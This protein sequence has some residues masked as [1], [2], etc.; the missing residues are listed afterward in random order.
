MPD[1]PRGT[2]RKSG[3]L[4]LAGIGAGGAAIAA[5]ILLRAASPAKIS[6]VTGILI[7]A[8]VF[9]IISFIAR[10]ALTKSKRRT[11]LDERFPFAI[12]LA[13]LVGFA[14]IT[15]LILA[16]IAGLIAGEP[17]STIAIKGL[18]TGLL[19]FATLNLVTNGI[20]DFVIVKRHLRGTLGTS[21]R[22]VRR[23]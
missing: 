14:A 5:L 20:L 9:N 17:F 13:K 11:I 1:Q 7:F 15:A 23:R 22:E 10:W 8:F 2:A 16:F 4:L 3:W 19:V 21:G 6:G 18:V 12:A